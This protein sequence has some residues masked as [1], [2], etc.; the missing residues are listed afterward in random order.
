[1]NTIKVDKN[2]LIKVLGENKKK[3]EEDYE[4]A[5]L[6]YKV[7]VEKALKSRLKELKSLPEL[8]LGNF[9]VGFHD[10]IKPESHVKEFDLAIGML[11]FSID[12]YVDITE[13]EY[14]EYYLGEWNWKNQWVFSNSQNMALYAQTYV[15]GKVK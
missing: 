2:E 10:I 9:H 1:M 6:G 7:A 15:D 5:V 4:K 8:E 3:H 14:R 11:N 13:Q 12:Q